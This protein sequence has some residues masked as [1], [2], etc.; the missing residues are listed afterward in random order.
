MTVAEIR[1]LFEYNAWA[2]KRTF[3][4]VEQVPTDQYMQDMK[5]SHGSIHGTLLH[6]VGAEKIWLD[7]WKQISN[8]TMLQAKDIPSLA[9][10]RKIWDAVQQ[11]REKFLASFTDDTVKT[12]MSE[13]TR[14]AVYQFKSPNEAIQLSTTKGDTYTHTFAQMMQHLVNH[15]T[16]HRGQITSLLRQIGVKPIGTDLITYFRKK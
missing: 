5:T 14:T 6:L 2:N 11:E 12:S 3:E 15:S 4:I 7:R 13:T 9:E 1:E 10:L 16:Y 8:P